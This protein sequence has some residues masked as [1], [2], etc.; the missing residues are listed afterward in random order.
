M[1]INKIKEVIPHRYPMLLI[2]RV[3]EIEIGKSAKGVK[4]LSYNEAFFQGHYPERPVMPGVL[5]VEALAQ[6]GAVA[7]LSMEEYKDTTPLFAGIDKARFKK[8]VVPGD[9]LELE[10]TL[11]R[12][13]GPIGFGKGLA[14]VD[15]EVACECQLMFYLDSS[16]A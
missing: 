8:Q 9:L 11:E 5:I 15:G 2:D 1:D 3:D 16:G 12:F 7:L 13:R 4:A 10:V 6:L 14:Q